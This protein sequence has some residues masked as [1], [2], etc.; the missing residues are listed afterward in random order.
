MAGALRALA[1]DCGAMA[2]GVAG[3]GGSLSLHHQV[4]GSGGLI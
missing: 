2:L 3:P 1:R 4:Q